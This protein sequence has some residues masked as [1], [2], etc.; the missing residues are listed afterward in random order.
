MNVLSRA[1]MELRL[2]VPDATPSVRPA[3]DSA[4]DQELVGRACGGD[5]RAFEVLLRRHYDGIHRVAWRLTGSASDADDLAQDV[6]CLLVEKLAGFKGEAKFTTW[7]YG[8]VVNAFRDH[9]RRSR[10]LKR[11][12]TGL[13]VLAA[14]AIGPDGRD[15]Y[16]RSWMASELSRLDP[17][18]RETVV[19]VIG[20]DMTHGEAANALGVAESTV[21]WRMHEAKRRLSA[22]TLKE[23]PD[24]L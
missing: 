24:D 7:L 3:F 21:S 8:V 14:L 10:T 13:S 2:V 1:D 12:R 17:L 5:R 18:L 15:L 22:R 4:A 20:E 16:R 9:Y 11:F 19:L 6:C 23:V